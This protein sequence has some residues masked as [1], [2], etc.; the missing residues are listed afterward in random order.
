MSD[1]E[2]YG[3]YNEY[4]GEGKGKS[5]LVMLI[6]KI[7]IA[8][9]CLSVV[10][11]LGARIFLF[12]YYPEEIKELY[13]TDTLTEYYNLTDGEMG[14]LSQSYPYM[15]DDPDEGNFFGGNVLVIRGAGMIQF[16]IRY[17][18]STLEKLS[19][20]YGKEITADDLVFTL[21]RNNTADG[22]KAI[23][24]GTLEHHESK[25]ILMYCYNK[26]VFSGIDFDEGENKI[27]WLRVRIT[28]KDTDTKNDEYLVPVYQNHANYDKFDEYDIDSDEVPKE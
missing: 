7:A 11:V 22:D 27:S 4:D 3:D 9:A 6:I 10:A 8:L 20:K 23:P 17:N 25:S 16:S 14:V 26:L 13:Y 5:G 19:E 21:E 2:R 12:N 1:F 24:L 28:I 18:N 15:Y